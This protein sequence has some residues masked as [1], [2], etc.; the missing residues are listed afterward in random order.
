[1]NDITHIAHLSSECYDP[2]L[3]PFHGRLRAHDPTIIRYTAYSWMMNNDQIA[4][5]QIC[6]LSGSLDYKIFSYK[7]IKPLRNGSQVGV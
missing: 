1:M 7:L 4:D 3:D 5:L 6:N 2:D